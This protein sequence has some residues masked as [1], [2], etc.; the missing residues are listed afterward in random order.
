M[1][2]QKWSFTMLWTFLISLP[3]LIY[4]ELTCFFIINEIFKKTTV[5][6]Y[7]FFQVKRSK[8]NLNNFH[9][10]LKELFSKYS[11]I[12]SF[13][14]GL[15]AILMLLGSV[16]AKAQVADVFYYIS[17]GND[18][19]YT[20]NRTTGAEV[21]IGATG[22]SD[23][24]AIA[25]YPIPG[26]QALYAADGGNFGTLNT[27]TGAFT[28]IG[29][30]DGG[31]TASGS[32]G[33]QSLDDVDGLMLD[34]QSLVMWAIQRNSGN[35]DLLFQINIATGQFTPDAFGAGVDYLEITGVGI[36][37]DVDDL[38]IDPGT[39]Q[40]YGVSNNGGSNDVLFKVNNATGVFTLVSTLSENDIEGLSFSNDGRLYGSDGGGENRLGEINIATGVFSNFQ[41]FSGSDVEGLA[42]LVATA[43]NITGTVYNDTDRNGIS[44]DGA[45][46]IA[47]VTLYLYVD[48]N[49]DGQIDPED[50]RVQS[51][52]T[53]G[54]GDYQFV[55][56][57]TGTL[58]ISTEP[59]TWSGGGTSRAIT[60]DNIETAVLLMG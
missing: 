8:S 18:R 2:T 21:N 28:L 19:L 33:E 22:V 14:I 29:E 16:L 52:V 40:I 1:K 4:R 32:A 53:D 5:D 20:I 6:R 41:S 17:D 35:P 30:V 3:V 50:T 25:Y 54:N 57:T 15:V 55:Y 60:T 38:A 34:G 59:D 31:G 51:T 44:D 36:A 10:F 11:S 48:R 58:L 13:K 12:T 23:I 47:G 49:G 24:E 46:G 26:S 37:I 27:S 9:F 7:G 39:G 43:N 45:G 56:I 42:A